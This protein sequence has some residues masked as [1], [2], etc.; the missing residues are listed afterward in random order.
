M[1]AIVVD[2]EDSFTYNI[3]QHLYLAGITYQVIPWRDYGKFTSEDFP[4]SLIVLGPGPGVASDY[5]IALPAQHFYLGI[6]LGHQLLGLAHGFELYQHH[7]LHGQ[8][9][10][11]VIPHWNCFAPAHRGERARV[12]RYNSWSLRGKGRGEISNCGM[13]LRG[14]NFLS[15]QFHPESLATS[16]PE[17]FFTAA[18]KIAQNWHLRD[19][20]GPQPTEITL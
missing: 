4:P 20:L 19:L 18:L 1:Q 6:C 12:Q 7:P 13:F 5:Q 17:R 10:E 11:V 8:A 14:H 9:V 15:Y 2:F 16:H 3:V